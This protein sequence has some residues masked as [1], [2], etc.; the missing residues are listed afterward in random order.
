MDRFPTHIIDRFINTSH[1]LA[2]QGLVQC[3]SGNLSYRVDEEHFL[4]SAT[5]AW[6]ERMSRDKIALCQMADGA[7]VSGPKPTV[8]L[9]L[10]RGILLNRPEMNVVIHFQSESATAL[11]CR[12][13]EI[14]YAVIPEIPYYLG[15][16][17]TI[18]YHPP[19][20]E[21]LSDAVSEAIKT[22]DLVVL[23]NHGVVTTAAGF[24]RALQNALFFELACKVV[25]QGGEPLEAAEVE[26]LLEWRSNPEKS[27]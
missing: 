25:L 21:A 23:R 22:S 4:V 7:H 11:A 27:V 18:P 9:G 20:S 12:S 8:E 14:N 26:S 1:H 15:T 19:G 24:D 17:A 13:G 3:S 16:V 5:G 2:R 6:L 10:H